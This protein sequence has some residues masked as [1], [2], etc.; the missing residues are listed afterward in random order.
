MPHARATGSQSKG[1][2]DS[3]ANWQDA[4]APFMIRKLI[5]L[6]AA[7]LAWQ[8]LPAADSNLSPGPRVPGVV[9]DHRPAS[10]GLY[11]GSPSL[12]VLTNGD[13]LASHDLFGP[14]SL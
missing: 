9:I 1:L 12:V 6:F 7:L 8:T 14:K 10:S 11:I 3:L 13:Y 2:S 4:A 5:P